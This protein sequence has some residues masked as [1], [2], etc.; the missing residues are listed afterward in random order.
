MKKTR[1]ILKVALVMAMCLMMLSLTACGKPVTLSINDCGT[2]T[3]FEAT[4]AMT[5]AD[6]L[7]EAQITLNEKD[8]TVPPVDEKVKEDT[9]EILIKRYAKVTIVKGDEK[10]EVELVGGTVEEAIKKSGITLN[11][12]EVTD[13]ENNAFL[14]D[15]MTINILKKITV[16][17]AADGKKNKVETT[18]KTV[19][20]LLKEQD[21]T[22]DEDDEVTK[23]LDTI[24][25]DGM[26]I[27]VKRVEYKE[28]TRT[29]T[30]DYKTQEKYSDSMAQGTSE[31]TQEG[32]EGEKEVTYKVK[33]VDSKEDSKEVLSEKVT[34]EPKD[35][36]VTY[37]TKQQQ[38][39]SNS[40]S[41]SQSSSGGKTVV[42][43]QA[44]PNCDDASHGY[45]VITYS[46]GTVDYQ[47]Y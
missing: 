20:E 34:K 14:T 21:I 43:K 24:L 31:V 12:N 32:V 37:G 30:I 1:T 45:Y 10:K 42:S 9:T 26:K 4:T 8:E 46:D 38:S 40:N 11:D 41:N 2:L 7:K 35:K 28:E 18:A 27:A 33:Y 6:V 36:I 3:E 25:K 5:V 22:L 23:P 47:E 29:E 16:T 19:E 15:G 17:L 39:N 13:A 44:V